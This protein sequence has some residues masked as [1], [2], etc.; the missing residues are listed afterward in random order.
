VLTDSLYASIGREQRPGIAVLVAKKGSI[1]YQKGFAYADIQSH[2]KITPLTKFRIGSITKQFTAAAILQL[3]EEGKLNVSDKLSKFF[4]EFPRAD[5]V[6]IH[7]LLTHTSGIHSYTNTD[8]FMRR[9]TAPISEEKLFAEIKKYPYDFNP[10]DEYRYNNSG[11]FL[12][13]YLIEKITGK[14]LGEVFKE[15]FFVPLKM[16]NTGMYDSQHKP[17]NEATGYEKNG[18]AYQPATDWDMSWAAGAGGL[19]STVED[20]NKWNNAFY[21]GKILKQESFKAAITPVMLNS[22]EKPPGMDYGYGLGIGHYRGFESIGHSGGLNGF[23]SQLVWYPREEM[24]VVMLTNQSPPELMLDPNRI[25]EFFAWQHMDTVETYEPID[26]SNVD[27]TIYEGRFQISKELLM[28]VTAE[29]QKLFVQVTGQQKY[30]MFPSKKDE[31]FLKVVEAVV[32][33]NRDDK[34]QVVSAHIEQGGF[35]AT[36]PKIKEQ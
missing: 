34:G 4:P 5:E 35:K 14:K 16:T 9:V 25:A 27:L 24:T 12:L 17:S 2:K 8:S 15:R 6:T 20:L 31:F 21:H 3:Q 26:V 28:D 23:I 1:V 22:G 11:Y 36:A 19:H 32:H 33:F 30:E 29:G 13:G 10:G 18:N 7:H